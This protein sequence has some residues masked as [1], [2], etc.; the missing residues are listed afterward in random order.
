MGANSQGEMVRLLEG[1]ILDIELS[2]GF[3]EWFCKS[4]LTWH[5]CGLY[6]TL[7]RCQGQEV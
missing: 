2:V 4:M 5:S 1:L 6:L 3:A 7:D